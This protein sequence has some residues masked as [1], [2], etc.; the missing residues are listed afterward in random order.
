MIFRERIAFKAPQV[1]EGKENMDLREI[2]KE[3]DELLHGL[4]KLLYPKCTRQ[5]ISTEV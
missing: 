3:K 5:Q 2:T 1:S 4:A